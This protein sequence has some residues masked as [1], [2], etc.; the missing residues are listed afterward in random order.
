LVPGILPSRP[1]LVCRSG[2]FGSGR[3][4]NHFFLIGEMI[5]PGSSYWNIGVGREIGDVEQD[6]EGLETMR[7]PGRNMA[8]LMKRLDGEG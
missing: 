6:E 4:G 3:K 1:G 7:T 2:G 8:W 5:V